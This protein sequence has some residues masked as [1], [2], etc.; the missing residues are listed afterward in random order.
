VPVDQLSRLARV[1]LAENLG[2]RDA[3]PA[4]VA[5]RVTALAAEWADHGFTAETVQPW[6]DLTPAGAAYLAERGIDPGVLDQLIDIATSPNPVTLRRAL[7]TGQLDAEKAYEV[8]VSAGDRR[9]PAPARPAPVD[10]SQ[11]DPAVPDPAQAPPGAAPAVFS[12]PVS[13]QTV[14]RRATGRPSQTPFRP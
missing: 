5:E 14:H 11:L 2:G 4:Q 1:L 9:S 13:D 12:H 6:T 3:V 10:A 7:S 8:L